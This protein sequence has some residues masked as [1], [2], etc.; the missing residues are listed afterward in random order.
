MSTTQSVP[1]TEFY[2]QFMNSLFEIHVDWFLI[3]CGRPD[4]QRVRP[5]AKM[6]VTTVMTVLCSVGVAF[7]LRFWLPCA[8][9]ANTSGLAT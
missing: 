5:E 2:E 9:S 6:V 7:Y 8:R 1:N 4:K 3:G